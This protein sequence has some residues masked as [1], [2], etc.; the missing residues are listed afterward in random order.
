MPTAS[1]STPEAPFM[2]EES[3]L[4]C[5]RIAAGDVIAENDLAAAVSDAFPVAV[6]HALIVSRRMSQASLTS[7]QLSGVRSWSSSTPFG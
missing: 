6:G 3:C 7:S 5:E 4:L 2:S 1:S